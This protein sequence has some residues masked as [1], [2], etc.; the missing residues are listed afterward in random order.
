[1]YI[2]IFKLNPSGYDHLRGG[3]VSSLVSHYLAGFVA[4]ITRYCLQ[5]F[6]LVSHQRRS[7]DE[8][9]KRPNRRA[10]KYKSLIGV[11]TKVPNRQ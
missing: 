10:I 2:Y 7:N 4:G 9:A 5:Y 3:V 11:K 8:P 1:M 6:P